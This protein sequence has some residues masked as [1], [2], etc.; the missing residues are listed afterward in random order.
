MPGSPSFLLHNFIIFLFTQSCSILDW[1][2]LIAGKG[3]DSATGFRFGYSLTFVIHV[4]DLKPAETVLACISAAKANHS[5][6]SRVIPV[7]SL[8]FNQSLGL[9]S[10][11]P[12]KFTGLAGL[13]SLAVDAG[14]SPK[15]M[16][17]DLP[18][19]Q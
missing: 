17:K 13:I 16:Q 9:P 2:L 14:V 19:G 6:F 15:N 10:K 4:S 5:A 12:T 11:R 7:P 1:C 3:G 18:S 8:T